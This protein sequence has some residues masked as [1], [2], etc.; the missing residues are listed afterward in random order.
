MKQI[1]STPQHRVAFSLL[2]LLM[3]VAIIAVLLALFLPSI[4]RIP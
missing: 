3:V 1:A 4:A 2:Q